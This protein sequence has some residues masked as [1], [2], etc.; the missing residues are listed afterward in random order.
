MRTAKLKL[1][2]DVD[3]LVALREVSLAYQSALNHAS[4]AAFS[5]G[6]TSSALKIHKVVYQDLRSHYGLPS[7][8]AC[9]VSRQVGANF[10]SLWTTVKQ[11]QGRRE[12][13]LARRA[14]GQGGRIPRRHKGLD[15][16]PR[17]ASRTTMYTLGRDYSF[18]KDDRVSLLTLQGRQTIPYEGWSRHVEALKDPATHIGGAKLWYQ[19]SS[20]TY[21]LLVSFEVEVPDPLPEDHQAVVGVD[22]GQRYHAVA[23]RYGKAG[24]TLF[25]SGKQV[26]EVKRRYEKVKKSLM[27]QGT[28]SARRRLVSIGSRERRFVADRNHQLSKTILNRFPQAL[29]GVEDLK[30]IRERVGPVRSRRASKRCKASNR[31]RSNWSFAEL[32]GF[33]AYKA[34]LHGSH[35]IKVDPWMTSQACPRCG[36]V[37]PENRPGKGLLF[38]C[39]ACGMKGHADLVAARNISM[40]TLL[41]RQDLARTGPLSTV[42]SGSST[43]DV[44][45]TEAEAR[46]RARARY[47]ELRWSPDASS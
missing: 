39:V 35:V 34:P 47:L 10:Q 17:Y 26:N 19:K 32:Q 44:S 12:A 25:A 24:K 45:G 23:T 9:S 15:Q 42:P 5:L 43:G 28:R 21:Y 37:G 16:A 13:A 8:L 31:R 11:A 14:A 7:Q 4:Q 46:K 41:A 3:Q 6:K 1:S 2:P 29:I 30:Q 38:R 33:L 27:R 18:K 40:R 36:H 22:V 20:K